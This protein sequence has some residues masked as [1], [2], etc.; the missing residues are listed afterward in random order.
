MESFARDFWRLLNSTFARTSQNI[1]ASATGSLLYVIGSV[2]FLPAIMNHTI[3]IGVW[4]FIG[5]SFFIGFVRA[6]RRLR[7]QRAHTRK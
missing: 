5:G 2:G 7:P 3:L 1:A 6:A 4:G